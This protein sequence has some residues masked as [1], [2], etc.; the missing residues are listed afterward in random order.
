MAEIIHCKRDLELNTEKNKQSFEL[1]QKEKQHYAEK[2]N[3]L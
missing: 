2:F 1:F 3:I